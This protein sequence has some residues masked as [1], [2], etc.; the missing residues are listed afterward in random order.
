MPPKVAQEGPNLPRINSDVQ[1]SHTDVFKM[2]PFGHVV[3]IKEVNVTGG[4]LPPTKGPPRVI[5]P[6]RNIWGDRKGAL[7]PSHR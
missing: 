4:G 5:I 1:G 2:R 7:R 6:Q 3:V